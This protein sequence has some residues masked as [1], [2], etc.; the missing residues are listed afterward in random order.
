MTKRYTVASFQLQTKLGQH[1][2]LGFCRRPWLYPDILFALS[3]MGR[4][5]KKNCD[6]VHALADDIIAK[7]KQTLVRISLTTTLHLY[8]DIII[9]NVCERLV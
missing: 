8:C 2:E 3:D 6:L 4:K 1:I 5:F 9:L 7:R